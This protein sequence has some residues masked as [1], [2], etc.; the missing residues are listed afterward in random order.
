MVVA[1]KMVPCTK[2]GGSGRIPAS[3]DR[4]C[5]KYDKARELRKQGLTV[6]EI[7][8]RLGYKSTCSVAAALKQHR[9]TP[10]MPVTDAMIRA[11]VESRA[12]GDEGE[13]PSL[14]DLL[15]FSAENKTRTVVRC[16]LEAAFATSPKLDHGWPEWSVSP[17][18]CE[19]AEDHEALERVRVCGWRT[20]LCAGPCP[21]CPNT[22]PERD[23]EMA[24][25]IEQ[26]N[27]LLADKG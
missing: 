1:M 17:G 19:H 12:K 9:I 20:G 14:G 8:K 22:H 25:W 21:S 26:Q 6:R 23:A 3:K 7:A 16:A 4:T 2:C 11:A 10:T 27:K 13:F 15:G 5:G 18:H 24:A